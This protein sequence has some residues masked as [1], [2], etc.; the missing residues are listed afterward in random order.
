MF[1]AFVKK[2]LG[3][4]TNSTKAMPDNA[5]KNYCNFA[6]ENINVQPGF[7]VDCRFPKSDKK[8][9]I[10]GED[11]MV[12]ASFIFETN[13][14]CVTIGPK[15]FVGGSTF[16]SINSISVGSNVFIAWGCY[17]YDHDS[18]SIDY[19]ER[20]NDIQQQLNDYKN[21]RNF[22]C[23]KNWSV[24]NS[25]PIIISDDAWIGMNS[26]ILKGV[27]VGEGAI[28]ASGSVVTKDVP[29]WTIVGGNPAKIIKELP[30]ELKKV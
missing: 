11:S 15:S 20:R 12:S 1:K 2:L 21:G 22:I 27:T 28:V 13:S 7:R 30:A 5:W 24:V 16:I 18:H 26:I 8:Y 10:V 29:P 3:Y 25:A 6:S 23:N 9:V 19:H 14:G 17:F 4:N